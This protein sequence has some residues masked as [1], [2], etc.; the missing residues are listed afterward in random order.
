[1]KEQEKIIMLKW[2]KKISKHHKLINQKIFNDLDKIYKNH[3][4]IYPFIYICQHGVNIV[5]WLYIFKRSIIIIVKIR[6][7]SHKL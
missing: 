2:S 5:E 6:M 7:S 4:S 3:L 1:M